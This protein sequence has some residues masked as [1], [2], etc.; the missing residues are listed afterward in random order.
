MSSEDRANLAHQFGL[1]S[2]RPIIGL[3]GRLSEEKGHQVLLSAVPRVLRYFPSTQFLFVGDGPLRRDL[4]QQIEQVGL[5]SSV[6]LVGFVDNVRKAMCLS[7]LMV[8]PS[9][10][11]S[12]PLSILEAMAQGKA[13]VATDV[14]SIREAVVAGE[15]GLLVPPQDP[16]A[17]AEAMIVMLGDPSRRIAMGEHG[18][19]LV[20]DRFSMATRVSQVQQVYQRVFDQRHSSHML[21]QFN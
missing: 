14:G 11:E 21:E 3:V 15:T 20:Q 17:L 5:T 1:D 10:S 6:R 13:V 9:L 7:D 8:Q 16:E 4:E 12:L 19:Q 18:A 2:R